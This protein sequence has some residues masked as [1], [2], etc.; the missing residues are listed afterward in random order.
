L[1]LDNL[2]IYMKQAK[3]VLP[4][5]AD[6]ITTTRVACVLAL[7]DQDCEKALALKD[8]DC[9]K[10]LALKDKDVALILDQQKK[11]EAY[12]MKQMSLLSQR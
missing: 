2:T 8:K 10:A 9:E 11:K 3:E 4:A 7:K 12:R 5:S 1:S 6:E